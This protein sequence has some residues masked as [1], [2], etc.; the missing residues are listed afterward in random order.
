MSDEMTG[1]R[2]DVFVSLIFLLYVVLQTIIFTV[3]LI[4][5][6]LLHAQQLQALLIK[7]FVNALHKKQ[8]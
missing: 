1:N 6:P 2:S 3:S 8:Q 4:Y 5:I 7:T